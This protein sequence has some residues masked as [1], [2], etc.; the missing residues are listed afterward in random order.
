MAPHQLTKMEGYMSLNEQ[1]RVQISEIR[2][3]WAIEKQEEIEQREED[4]ISVRRRLRQALLQHDK[5]FVP[6][7][8]CDAFLAA[9]LEGRKPAC[10]HT[11]TLGMTSWLLNQGF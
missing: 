7:C 4:E 3:R 8:T 6:P 10:S 1:T 5:P 9:A 2:K 11:N